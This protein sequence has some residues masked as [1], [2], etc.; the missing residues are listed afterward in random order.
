MSERITFF[1][2]TLVALCGCSGAAVPTDPSIPACTIDQDDSGTLSIRGRKL[3][4]QFESEFPEDPDYPIPRPKV[5]PH[6]SESVLVAASPEPGWHN[7]IPMS[8][9]LW[10][11]DCDRPHQHR[12]M[13]RVEDAAFQ[14][15]VLKRDG[16]GLY[17][18]GATSVHALDLA[19][20]AIETL[21]SPPP[22]DI[23]TCWGAAGDGL[24]S[25]KDVVRGW[26]GD[27]RGILVERGGPC[28]FEADW[29]AI[30]MV[31][32]H[33]EEPAKRRLHRPHPVTSVSVETNGGIWLA[34]GGRCDEPGT[35]DPVTSEG[36]WH[37]TDRGETW[38]LV[39]IVTDEGTRVASVPGL[40]A[41]DISRPGHILVHTQ[42]CDTGGAII[43]GTI[44][45]TYDG[46]AVWVALPITDEMA[47][48]CYLDEGM[49]IED[50]VIISGDIDHLAVRFVD[51]NSWWQT[52]NGGENWTK[53]ELEEPYRDEVGVV[54]SHGLGAQA[55]AVGEDSSA[56]CAFVPTNDGL[57]RFCEGAAKGVRVFPNRMVL[58][59][60]GY[61]VRELAGKVEAAFILGP[62]T[63]KELHTLLPA[64]VARMNQALTRLSP[65]DSDGFAMTPPPWGN[66]IKLVAGDGR[67]AIVHFVGVVLR[68]STTRPLDGGAN[69]TDPGWWTGA[70]D[71]PLAEEDQDWLWGLMSGL[72]GPTAVKQY[73]SD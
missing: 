71:L 61:L 49:G 7:E 9:T 53:L 67:E 23:E 14:F 24:D 4:L 70:A 21:T 44:F 1:L 51:G 18:T 10:Q 31:L 32:L 42:I 47:D 60:V 33:P 38:E 34:D 12:E 48:S 36:V 50:F 43:G 72:L 63:G 8:E 46:G 25:Y 54:A 2:L 6:D 29:E 3:P 41:A 59:G 35:T 62:E 40:V 27:G 57:L 68:I 52:I 45:L 37:S 30:E 16:T 56:G 15:G 22:L 20:G 65:E 39:G 69:A 64:D 58:E 11:V 17:F 19:S 73:L 5:Y 26:S 66:P 55:P 13:A 28:G